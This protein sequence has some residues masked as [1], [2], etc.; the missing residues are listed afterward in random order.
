MPQRPTPHA[1][2]QYTTSRRRVLKL[3]GAGL[4][5][6]AAYPL[7]SACASDDSPGT[8]SSNGDLTALSLQLPWI[9]DVEFAPIFLADDRGHLADEG[10]ELSMIA[11]GPDIGAIEGIVAGGS[12]QLGI[13]TDITSIIAAAADGNPLVCLGALYQE[14]LNCLISP[15]DA[16]ILTVEDMVGKR[17]GGV[18]GVQTKYDA[19]FT[20]AGLEPDY[21]FV[22]VGYGPDALINGDVDVMGAFITDEVLAFEAATGSAPA[23]LTYTDAGL[24]AYTLVFF[25]TQEMLNSERDAIKGLLRGV[26]RGFDDWV[27]EPDE[28]ARLAAEVYGT[29]FGLDLDTEIAKAGAYLPLATSPTTDEHGYLYLDVDFI[30]GDIF[31]GMEAAGLGTAPVDEIVDMSLL[32][33]INA[34]G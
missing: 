17:V 6:L 24:P 25:T 34:E 7:L 19:M 9:M 16:P 4:M 12:T 23:I 33:E 13:A 21:T 2:N 18:Q 27:A 29:D 8:S 5:G 14:N 11:G 15:P 32:D 30:A 20:L 3:G 28:G 26:R 10:V 31:R 1:L 22:P